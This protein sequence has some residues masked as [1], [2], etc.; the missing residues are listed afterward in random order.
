MSTLQTRNDS[1]QHGD[2]AALLC[3]ES[4]GI[5]QTITDQITQLGFAIHSAF[6]AEEAISKLSSHTYNVVIIEENLEGTDAQTH[7]VL[8]ELATMR[9]DTRRGFYVVLIGPGMETQSDTQAFG[10]SVD[11]TL[12]LLDMS[13]LKQLVG[14]GIVEQEEFYA[15]FK[16]VKKDVQRI[17]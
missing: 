9:L 10:L 6:T 5:Q 2:L 13:D 17:G 15:A 16:A 14:R 7:P 4:P 12:N 1:F 11:L 3:I 8:A